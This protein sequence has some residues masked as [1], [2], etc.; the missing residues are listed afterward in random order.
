MLKALF[1]SILLLSNS[2]LASGSIAKPTPLILLKELPNP[3]SSPIFLN[4]IALQNQLFFVG[5]TTS[6]GQ[7]LWVTDGTTPGTRLVQDLNPGSS[8]GFARSSNPQFLGANRDRIFLKTDR[9]NQNQPQLWSSNGTITTAIASTNSQFARA[10]R[11]ATFEPNIPPAAIV[12]DNLLIPV[13]TAQNTQLWQSN[14]SR[15]QL[16]KQWNAPDR[17]ANALLQL[18]TNAGNQAFFTI[19]NT[20]LARTDGTT[21][22][23]IVLATV[24]PA[25]EPFTP[26]QGR[27]YF[28]GET[29]DRG[30]EWWTSDGTVKGTQ[31]LADILPGPNSS[32]PRMLGGLGQQ[33]F[34]L[35]NS[36][37]GYELWRTNG[38]PSTTQRVK[39]LSNQPSSMANRKSFV[40]QGKLFFS[41]LGAQG[42]ELWVTDGTE[43]GTQPLVQNLSQSIDELV[44]FQNRL[45]FRAGNN[46][47]GQELWVSD[48]TAKGTQMV[49]D[50]SP[51]TSTIYPPCAPP[52]IGIPANCQPMITPNSAVPQSLTVKGDRLYF[53]ATNPSLQQGMGQSLWFTDGTAKGTK[54]VQTLETWG[55]NSRIVTIGS[56]HLVNGYDQNRQRIQI[57]EIR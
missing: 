39:R 34:A 50:L 21:A 9:P 46:T 27:I 6:Q 41:F 48:G 23:T 1:V 7:E 40:H 10:L 8:D 32:A 15:T 33:F 5:T 2:I 14:G 25:G 37:Q 31:L 53:V 12:N 56:R 18:F 3:Q 26:W 17:S 57:W 13:V 44:S 54:L 35:A 52:P 47:T 49:I 29:P 51:G 16:L 4:P 19:G 28:E 45:Y 43:K 38:T 42:G 20:Q 30:F 22:G 24:N 11:T 36:P 55:N